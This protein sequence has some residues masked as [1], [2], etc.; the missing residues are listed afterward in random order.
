[1]A[2]LKDSK[3]KLVD[4]FD[5]PLIGDAQAFVADPAAL[6][7]TSIAAPA[8]TAVVTTAVTQTS[9]FGYVGAAQGDAVA[10]AINLL[11]THTTELDLDYEALLVDVAALRTKL[12]AVLDI[13]EEHGL[14]KAS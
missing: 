5:F 7:A 9:P 10:T 12:I 6:T 14:M 13:L 11:V 8:T 1:M 3:S 4:S 2:A